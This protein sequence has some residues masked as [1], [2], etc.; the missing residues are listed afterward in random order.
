MAVRYASGAKGALFHQ[1]QGAASALE[2]VPTSS[3]VLSIVME[4]DSQGSFI[5]LEP[6]YPIVP[7][8]R[9][10]AG[11][12]EVPCLHDSY[13]KIRINKIHIP[14][15]AMAK[16]FNRL[17]KKGKIGSLKLA[18]SEAKRAGIEVY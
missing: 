5:D 4:S 16:T 10:E 14:Y 8:I 2:A 18:I 9:A 1:Q 15:K 11:I 6:L 7:K 13:S 12:E 3:K 17:K